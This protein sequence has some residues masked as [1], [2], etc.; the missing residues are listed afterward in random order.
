M[1]FDWKAT[2]PSVKS[3]SADTTGFTTG[4]LLGASPVP[5]RKRCTTVLAESVQP[6]MRSQPKNHVKWKGNEDESR[7]GTF[8]KATFR[9]NRFI[10]TCLLGRYCSKA[11]PLQLDAN[12]WRP[13]LPAVQR[14]TDC[15]KRT[16]HITQ[17]NSNTPAKG[18]GF[19]MDKMDRDCFQSFHA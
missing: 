17:T 10:R 14:L 19:E 15:P 2:V 4:F 8:F 6:G 11:V 13:G 5:L 1:L 3:F 12:I 9:A 18:T 16:R 7:L